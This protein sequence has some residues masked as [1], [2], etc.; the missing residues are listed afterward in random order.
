MNALGILAPFA[1]AVAITLNALLTGPALGQT[2]PQPKQYDSLIRTFDPLGH[3]YCAALSPDGKTL[4]TST[5]TRIVARDARSGE[6]AHSFA[7]KEN[8]GA[9]R[10]EFSPDGASVFSV[11]GAGTND[12]TVRKWSTDDGKEVGRFEGHTDCV[13]GLALSSDGKQLATAGDDKTV[14]IWD[15]KTGEESARLDHPARVDCVAFAP[16]KPALASGC[17][18]HF[19]RLWNTK[20]RSVDRKL[21]HERC[22]S[23][24]CFSADG[25]LLASIGRGRLVVWQTA[26]GRQVHDLKPCSGETV[27][28][29]PDGAVLAAGGSNDAVYLWDVA[30]GQ[31]NAVFAGH[32]GYVESIRFSRDGKTLVTTGAD[33]SVRLWD[34]AAAR[35]EKAIREL[36]AREL[37]RAW[38]LLAEEDPRTAFEAISALTDAPKSSLPFLR[39]HLKSAEI[40][41]DQIARWI[42][43]LDSDEFEAREAATTN[44]SQHAEQARAQLRKA[45]DAPKSLEAKR[46]LEK[47]V[48]SLDSSETSRKRRQETRVL[49]VLEKLATPEATQV[50]EEL[51]KGADSAWL[52]EQ[53]KEALRRIRAAK[54]SSP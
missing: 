1:P 31:R 10:F 16:D 34:V 26:T 6:I 48:T 38:K 23:Y 14:R 30:S 40:K 22:I 43:D 52:T 2:A 28:F 47:I 42:T 3:A 39:D 17:S 4:V 20:T 51:N 13:L 8:S 53:A 5:G 7:T 11:R 19:I 50:L 37:E 46:R 41:T 36:P 21:D 18:D 29:S 54:G 12:Y 15:V 32:A 44:L 35:N 27:A 49:I 24:L 9:L 25:A 45:L 33:D